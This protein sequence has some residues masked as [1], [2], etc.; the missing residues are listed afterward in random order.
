[1]ARDRWRLRQNQDAGDAARA[2]RF[3]PRVPALGRTGVFG[4]Y[5]SLRARDFWMFNQ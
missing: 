2:S 5:A 1:M 4:P 3:G